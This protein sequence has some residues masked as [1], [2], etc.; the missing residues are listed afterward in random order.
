LNKKQKD[1][2]K[3]LIRGNICEIVRSDEVERLIE[4][5]VFESINDYYDMI[6]DGEKFL[7]HICN[8]RCLVQTGPGEMD[9]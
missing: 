2:I 3:D 4:E 1:F 8:P 5:G 9:F 6:K 7:Q